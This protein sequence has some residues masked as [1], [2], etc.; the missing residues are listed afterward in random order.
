MSSFENPVIITCSISGTVANR[1]QCPAIP[2]TPEEYAAEARRIVDEGGSMIHIHARKPDGTPSYE[3]EDF[4]NITDAILSEVDDVAINYSTG[5]V[6]VPIEKRIEY[7]RALRPEVGALNM[8][9][10]NYAKYSGRRKS[11]VFHTVFENSFE[12][13]MAFVNVMNELGIKPEHECFDS[14][15]VANLDPLIDMG[16]LREPFQI[17]CVMGV[18]G[19]I[20]PTARNLAHMSEQIPGGAEGPNNW[21]VIGI[22]RRQ[23]MLGAAALTLGGN[24]RVG[25]EDNFYLPDG[26]MARSNGDLVAKARQM[27][28]DVGRRPAT[29]TETRELLGIEKMKWPPEPLAAATA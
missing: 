5:A 2:Y 27:V 12:T 8:G 23:W 11:F 16:L 4:R 10:M 15:H 29:A 22:S 14:G 3:V 21:G 17:S 26:E 25:L 7:L 18:T 19:G 20:R 13:I 9:S 24:F 6:G 28:E 1:D